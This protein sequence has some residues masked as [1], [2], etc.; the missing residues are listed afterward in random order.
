MVL[1]CVPVNPQS[2]P[3]FRR[4]SHIEDEIHDSRLL[5][6]MDRVNRETKETFG[7]PLVVDYFLK[8][9]PMIAAANYVSLDANLWQRLLVQEQD[10]LAE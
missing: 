7:E 10:E 6:I 5:A 3:G 1:N 4:P 9:R 8:P 2:V